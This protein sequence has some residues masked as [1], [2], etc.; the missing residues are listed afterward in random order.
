MLKSP[1]DFPIGLVWLSVLAEKPIMGTEG[2]KSIINYIN[3]KII[4][5]EQVKKND[6]YLR[7]RK[8]KN[9]MENNIEINKIL[10]LC[11]TR[12][13]KKWSQTALNNDLLTA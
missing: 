13:K 12:K 4:G 11:L 8:T 2:R 7:T 6:L 1:V 9:T 10:I 5:E 3:H